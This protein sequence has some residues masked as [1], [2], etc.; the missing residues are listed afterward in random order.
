MLPYTEMKYWDKICWVRRARD[1][2][3]SKTYLLSQ[4]TS[5]PVENVWVIKLLDPFSYILYLLLLLN[6]KG[7]WLNNKRSGKAYGWSA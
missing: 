2:L 6:C 7:L 5:C 3:I 4:E 1:H